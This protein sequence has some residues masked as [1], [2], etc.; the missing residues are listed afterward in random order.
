MGIKE[1]V[2]NAFIN[3]GGKNVEAIVNDLPEAGKQKHGRRK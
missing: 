1:G 2:A 3:A